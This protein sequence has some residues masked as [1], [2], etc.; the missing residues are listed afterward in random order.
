LI[1][2]NPKINP[3]LYKNPGIFFDVVGGDNSG[4]QPGKTCPPTAPG[5]FF[6]FEA[7]TGW[8]RIYK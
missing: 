7:T 6:G 4:P 3:L 8:V 1:V 5:T 2:S